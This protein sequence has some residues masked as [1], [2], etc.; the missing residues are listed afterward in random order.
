MHGHEQADLVESPIMR[1]FGGKFRSVVRTLNK[2][3]VVTTEHW[4]S[5]HLDVLVSVSFFI[6]VLSAK[7]SRQWWLT[8]KP[9][10]A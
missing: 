10:T 9:F 2:P 5:L 8:F 6:F 3:D 1:I 7:M 4:R